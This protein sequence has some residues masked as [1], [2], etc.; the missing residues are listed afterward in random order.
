MA[1]GRQ[2]RLL[3]VISCGEHARCTSDARLYRY[4]KKY[5]YNRLAAL[6]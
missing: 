1:D 5:R 3:Q 6:R 4:Q 2:S